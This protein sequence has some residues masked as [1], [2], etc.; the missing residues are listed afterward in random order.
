MKAVLSWIHVICLNRAL[1]G[2]RSLSGSHPSFSVVEE[3]L[4]EHAE[5][6]PLCALR[7]T[8]PVF[9]SGS[10]TPGLPLLY[11]CGRTSP[12]VQLSVGPPIVQRS[13]RLPLFSDNSDRRGIGIRSDLSPLAG[14]EPETL[15]SVVHTFSAQRLA[16]ASVLWP[17]AARPCEPFALFRILAGDANGFWSK[18]SGVVC[19]NLDTQTPIY[20]PARH[21]ARS[22]TDHGPCSNN[23]THGTHNRFFVDVRNERPGI[24]QGR[25]NPDPSHTPLVAPWSQRHPAVMG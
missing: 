18:D 1:F 9:S 16:P 13:T 22:P 14:G 12:A 17:S 24:P 3:G 2:L 7:S 10:R 8:R 25:L 6:I 19:S 5:A 15:V 21:C 4:T 20:S 11:F 23:N